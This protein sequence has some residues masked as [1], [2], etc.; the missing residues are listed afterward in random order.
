MRL[1]LDDDSLDHKLIRQL[2][3][4]GHEVLV[5]AAVS[6]AGES[7][8]KHLRHAATHGLALLTRNYRD[9][10]D[11][12]YLVLGCAGRYSG[13]LLVRDEANRARNMSA[14]AISTAVTNLEKS[15]TELVNQLVILNHW[16]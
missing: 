11:L 7:D 10:E 2:T 9:F 14:R 1:Y 6:L 8:P 3:R 12:H 13:I 15:Q 4:D 5:P 16:R